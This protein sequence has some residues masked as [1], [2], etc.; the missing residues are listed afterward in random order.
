MS[1]D[2]FR[3]MGFKEKCQ[4]ENSCLNR[5]PKNCEVGKT[6]KELELNARIEYVSNEDVE[7]SKVLAV[8]EAKNNIVPTLEQA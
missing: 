3:R 5:H 6:L 8:L 1:C 2:I 4:L 7:Q